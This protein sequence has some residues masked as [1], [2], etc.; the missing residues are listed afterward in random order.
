MDNRDLTTGNL[1]KKMAVFS[2]PLMI[3]NLLQAIYNIVDMIIVGRYVGA[4]GLS[5]VSVGGQ[6]TTLVLCIA[7]GL[8]D[9]GAV[10]VGQLTGRNKKEKIE[11]VISTMFGMFTSLAI[12]LTVLVCVFARPLLVLLN[13]PEESFG[14]AC[15]YLRICMTGAVFVYLFNLLNGVF[16][17]MGVSMVPMVMAGCSSA[18]NILLD[19]VF[20]GGLALGSSGAAIATVCSQFVSMVV[21]LVI[22]KKR[23]I[24]KRFSGRLFR[25]HREALKM[26]LKIGVPQSVEFAVTNVSFLFLVGMA[27]T[28]GVYASAAA[29]SVS[30]ISTFAVLLAQ[31][32][33]SAVVTVTAQNVGAGKPM[34]AL[35]GAWIGLCYVV[36]AALMFL[37][38]SLSRPRLLLQLFAKEAEVLALGAPYL[39]I[40]SVSFVIESVLFCFMGVVAG[41]GYTKVT[42][43]CTLVDALFV[44]IPAA[45]LC[46]VVLGM[47]FTGIGWAYV[48]APVAALALI[49]L[50][51][52]SGKWKKSYIQME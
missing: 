23:G 36:P 39:Q 28:Y 9:A 32:M 25:M 4:A 26:V 50:F 20:V 44:R 43:L 45:K 31:A 16:R 17:G 15:T 3:M 10:I 5:A 29:G 13:T 49:T 48:C 12:L 46:S 51:L 35:K 11:H 27:N 1:W 30:K 40:V 6:V 24:I 42:L 18:V 22:A 33:L 52:M 14:Y 38:L 34:R 37:L 7:L 8:S 2:V 47:G 41:A 21:L 19:L